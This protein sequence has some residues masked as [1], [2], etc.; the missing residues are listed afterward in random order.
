MLQLIVLGCAVI[1]IHTRIR[2]SCEDS[3]SSTVQYFKKNY[4]NQLVHSTSTT[5]VP[6]PAIILIIIHT[7]TEMYIQP[8][9]IYNKY[10]TAFLN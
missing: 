10:C 7:I 8:A 1:R 3:I 5:D 4:Q 9:V 2:F 6:K